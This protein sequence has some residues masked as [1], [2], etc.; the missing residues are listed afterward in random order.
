MIDVTDKR[1][2]KTALSAKTSIEEEI[3]RF[4]AVTLK[5]YF[6]GQKMNVQSNGEY[7]HYKRLIKSYKT[8]FLITIDGELIRSRPMAIAS[9]DENDNSIW[10]LTSD[11]SHKASELSN[12]SKSAVSCMS[13]STMIT[14][15]GN[16][17]IIH[18][19]DLLRR[20]WKEE[21]REWFPDG[22]ETPHLALIKFE[23]LQ[24]EY[25]DKNRPDS[26][27][28]FVESLRSAVS[29][30]SG[31]ADEANQHGRVIL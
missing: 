27:Q 14:V 28:Y 20:F 26:L 2:A 1:A 30:G 6:I 7:S 8:A 16:S 29:S 31:R 10:F 3:I 25:W 21:F 19:T 11:S 9:I 5:V 13:S 17:R 24:A 15:S 22:I 18:D 23:P 4:Q 12:D